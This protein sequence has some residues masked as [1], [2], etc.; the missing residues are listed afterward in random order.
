MS[1]SRSSGASR[2][3]W[4]SA[5]GSLAPGG[6]GRGYRRGEGSSA[7]SGSRVSYST[8]RTYYRNKQVLVCSDC[9]QERQRK[10]EKAA[11]SRA[12]S[13]EKLWIGFAIICFIIFVLYVA[14]H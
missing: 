3:R 11:E 10:I 7:Y 5:P 14:H 12:Q 1:V 8:G 13:N 9:H 4:N 2:S 6:S